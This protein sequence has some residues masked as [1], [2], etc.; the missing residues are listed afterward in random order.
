VNPRQWKYLPWE[1]LKQ[2]VISI[3]SWQMNSSA[4]PVVNA[5][6]MRVALMSFLTFQGS[7]PGLFYD[8]SAGEFCPLRIPPINRE[9]YGGLP[10]VT[11]K[12]HQGLS[13]DLSGMGTS[14]WVFIF[15]ILDVIFFMD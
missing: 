5:L 14:P 8:L 6:I 12:I 15:Y 1:Q 10:P 11:Q 2:V 7:R 3:N 4:N 9:N 13:L